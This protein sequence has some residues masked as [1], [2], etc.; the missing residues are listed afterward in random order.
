MGGRRGVR[1]PRGLPRPTLGPQAGHAPQPCMW[2]AMATKP[3][4]VTSYHLAHGTQD[5]QEEGRGLKIGGRGCG[6]CTVRTTLTR[7]G[8]ERRAAPCSGQPSPHTHPSG[9]A[10]T[11]GRRPQRLGPHNPTP[12]QTWAT[13]PLPHLS[14]G[15]RERAGC[16]RETAVWVTACGVMCWVT[17]CFRTR[18]TQEGTW[19]GAEVP[20]EGPH[21]SV[22]RPAAQ[23]PATAGAA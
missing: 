3:S 14:Q 21:R 7:D 1:G 5:G 16:G 6:V 9:T 8:K 13:P 19:Q 15:C 18:E 23:V 12:M 11:F 20:W 4:S 2:E 17:S 10:P 22:L